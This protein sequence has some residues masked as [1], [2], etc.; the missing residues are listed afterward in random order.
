M[1]QPAPFAELEALVN[2]ETVAHLSNAVATFAGGE[3]V[4]G[5]FDDEHARGD[6]GMLSMAD[7]RPTFTLL[8][9]DIPL[10]VRNWFVLYVH[11]GLSHEDPDAVDL[12]LVLRGLTYRVTEHEP[13]G[14]GISTL[15]LK[16]EPA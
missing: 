4:R 3:Q 8:T 11:P 5:I 14:T 15:V 12:R 13:D 16:R 1:N 2:R 6:V 9:A 7:S 10:A